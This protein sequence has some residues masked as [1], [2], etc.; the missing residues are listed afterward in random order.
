MKNTKIKFKTCV[1]KTLLSQK[2]NLEKCW[3]PNTMLSKD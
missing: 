2:L 3:T 1:N